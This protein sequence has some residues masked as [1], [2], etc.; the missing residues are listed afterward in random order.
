MDEVCI[1]TTL[2]KVV[3]KKVGSVKQGQAGAVY[4]PREW[5]GRK[6]QVILVDE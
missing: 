4:L 1:K 3:I 2:D 5:I 6:V